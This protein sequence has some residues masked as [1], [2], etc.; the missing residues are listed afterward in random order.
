MVGQVIA[1][2]Y[3][4][5]ELV[6]SGGM[7]SVF[8]AHDR[9]LE[10]KVALKILHEHYTEDEEY[11]ERFRR[12]ARA[13]AGLAHPNIV[14]VIDRGEE[15]GKQFIVFE[16]IAGENLKE[17]VR[18]VGALSVTRALEIS[19]EVGN[20]LAFAHANGLVHRDVKPQNVL[21]NGDGRA[22]VTD[23]GIARSLD[24]EHG[25]TQTGTVLG[26]SSYIA[27]EQARGERVDELSDVY[28]LGVVVFELLAGDV[29]FPG[30]SF[31]AVAM[32]H[33]NE[34]PPDIRERR[35][36]VSPRLA[37]A[38]DAA[39]AKEPSGRWPSM[40]AFVDELQSCLRETQSDA[41]ATMIRAPQPAAPG[42][43]AARRPRGARRS[44]WPLALV[45]AGLAALAAVAWLALGRDD[46]GGKGG[47]TAAAAGSAVPLVA[48]RSWD[49]EGSN[50]EHE[51]KIS[52]ATD[53]DR[54]TAWDTETYRSKL[55]AIKNGVG[56]VLDAKKRAR[57][58][59]LTVV[60]PT[61][62]F[63]AVVQSGDSD[64]GPFRTVSEPKT[65]GAT[66]TWEING[67]P[68]RYYTVWITDLPGG[69]AGSAEIAEATAKAKSSG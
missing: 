68:A 52:L 58:G 53:G 30:D 42:Y 63:T 4:L 25:V 15:D 43:H 8:R 35:S 7:S 11:V 18:D 41:G 16:Y 17:H 29:P 64:G 38:I 12:E 66:T 21:L 14:T 62:G 19:L 69:G 55:S 57:L 48:V 27:P 6:G 47:T 65:A 22:K 33:I 5:E 36:D 1:G 56:I 59:T 3:E 23:F 24:V 45:L 20:A 46:G 2:R 26:T 39:L 49:P 37:A 9:L 61:P 10:R 54:T 50:V 32:K 34:P 13:V 28:S 67:P 51:D 40:Q 60:S 31:V 44:V